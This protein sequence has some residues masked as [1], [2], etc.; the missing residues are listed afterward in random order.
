M[1]M[2]I[3][4]VCLNTLVNCCWARIFNPYLF[5]IFALFLLVYVECC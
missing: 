4:Y 2:A 5:D 3:G 1:T